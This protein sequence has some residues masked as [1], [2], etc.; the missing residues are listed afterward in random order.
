MNFVFNQFIL[1]NSIVTQVHVIIPMYTLTNTIIL[2]LHLLHYIQSR[3]V[4]TFLA[5]NFIE[6]SETN[7]IS[8]EHNPVFIR[9]G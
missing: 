2:D 4:Y 9:L 5:M 1:Q 7:K 8:E 6:P 3:Q